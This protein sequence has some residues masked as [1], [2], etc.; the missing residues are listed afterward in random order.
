MVESLPDTLQERVV[1][2][3]R[4]FI[5]DLEDEEK[6]EASFKRFSAGEASPTHDHLIASAQAAKQAVS[7][8]SAFYGRIEMRLLICL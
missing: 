4:E 5:A 1:E 8:A 6:W 3:V 2:H 7:A